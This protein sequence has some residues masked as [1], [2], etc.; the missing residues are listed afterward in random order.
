[1]N[2]R[3]QAVYEREFESMTPDEMHKVT[4]VVMALFD[5]WELSIA[6]KAD[7]LGM[8]ASSRATL[9]AYSKKDSNSSLPL[10]RD[11][12]DRTGYLLAIHKALRLLYPH[13]EAMRFGW[14]RRRNRMLN[15]NAPLD[16]MRNRGLIGIAAIARYLDQLRGM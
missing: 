5:K 9:A 12:Q 3:A 16:V 14:V 1:M 6:E 4:R 15:G 7:L 10:N 2:T 13:D 8:Q 11:S